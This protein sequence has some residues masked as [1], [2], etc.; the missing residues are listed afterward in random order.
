MKNYRYHIVIGI[1][2]L[3]CYSSFSAFSQS[4]SGKVE[5]IADEK[6][7]ELIEKH[8]EISRTKKY[9]QGFRIHIFSESGSNS[10]LAAMEIRAKF[11]AK[12]PNSEVYIVFQE[13][14]YKVRVGNFRSRM[15]ARGFL[16]DILEDY[17]NAYVIKDFIDFPSDN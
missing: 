5:I 8:L 15:N 7:A 16:K 6:V 17:P 3:T 10:K 9:I 12:H 11:L 13:P 2:I 1:I 4:K 14:N